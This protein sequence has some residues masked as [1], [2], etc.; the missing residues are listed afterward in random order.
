M[1]QGFTNS[2]LII[3]CEQMGMV[4]KSGLSAF[5][6][7]LLMKEDAGNQR[8]EVSRIY[9]KLAEELEQTGIL[10]DAMEEYG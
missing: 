3:F 5:E 4:L 9:E 10:Y 6:G 8:A 2:E 1:R 7:I